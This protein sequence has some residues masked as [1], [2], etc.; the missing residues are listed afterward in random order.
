MPGGRSEQRVCCR[1]LQRRKNLPE[2]SPSEKVEVDEIIDVDV[3]VAIEP[4]PEVDIEPDGD[5]F[6]RL[7]QTPT[8]RANLRLGKPRGY[9]PGTFRQTPGEDFRKKCICASACRQ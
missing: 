3:R 1:S 7:R 4:L 5:F 8:G 9:E 2:P 6:R